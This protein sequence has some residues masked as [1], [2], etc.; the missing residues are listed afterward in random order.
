MGAEKMGEHALRRGEPRAKGSGLSSQTREELPP[1][2]AGSDGA[3]G[4]HRPVSLAGPGAA[5]TRSAESCR[6]S[7][8]TGEAPS[9][10]AQGA[11]P[12]AAP[13]GPA[14]PQLLHC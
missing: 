13:R 10:A 14:A 9:D 5:P 2:T 7:H 1:S 4:A 6:Q 8:R 12:S 3:P 11:V